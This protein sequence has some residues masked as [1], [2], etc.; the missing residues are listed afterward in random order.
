M[1]LNLK[2]L[3]LH[4][5]KYTAE[6]TA[7]GDILLLHGFTGSGRDW[8]FI[9]PSL[10]SNLNIYTPDIIGHGHSDSP[11]NPDLYKMD[12]ILTQL[13]EFIIQI[14]EYKPIL[15][16][17]SMGG[18]LALSYTLKYPEKVKCLILESSTWGIENKDLR[19]QRINDDKKTAEFILAAGIE[20]FIEFWMNKGI[21]N[22][23]KKL[24]DDILKN[25]RKNK[26]QNNPVGLSNFLLGSGTG[27]ME[28]LREK[29][30]ELKIPVL[31]ITG[32]LDK[33]F[34]AINSNMVKIFENAEH[35]I[36]PEAGHNVHLEKPGLFINVIKDFLKKLNFL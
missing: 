28:P 20:N 25:V 35:I 16:G 19:R 5:Y 27:N 13:N 22:S 2:D 6:N 30:S 36:V 33:K 29:I 8:N 12:A 4:Y 3:T 15:L 21:F 9:I 26:L 32:G 14:L 31:L 23:Q 17:Y 24:S 34:S 10:K 1:K 18:R 11:D 7:R